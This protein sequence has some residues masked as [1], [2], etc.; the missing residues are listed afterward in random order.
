MSWKIWHHGHRYILPT[1]LSLFAAVVIL[2]PQDRGVDASSTHTG[3]ASGSHDSGS[4]TDHNPGHIWLSVGSPVG[5]SL[6]SGLRYHDGCHNLNADLIEYDKC[7]DA[8]GGDF[9]NDVGGTGSAYLRVNYAGYA[10]GYTLQ[11]KSGTRVII[12][13]VCRRSSGP[14][15]TA[16][17]AASRGHDGRGGGVAHRFAELAL[18][19]VQSPAGIRPNCAPVPISL[20]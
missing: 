14:P 6:T 8:L 18:V 20:T 12:E 16:G 10:S 1:F 7:V 2:V 15:A 4:H 9:A 19:L 13:V 3:T 17:G 11:V 5:G